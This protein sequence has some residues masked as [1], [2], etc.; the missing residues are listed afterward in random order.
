MPFFPSPDA[1]PAVSARILSR[2]TEVPMKTLLRC[3]SCGF[4]IEEGRLPDVCPACGVPRKLFEP[5]TETVSEKRL[6]VLQADLHPIAVH[7]PQ[8]YILTLLPLVGL[9]LLVP[10]WETTL[11]AAIRVLAWGLPFSIAL[12]MLA[13]LIDGKAR[14]RRLSTPILK[15]KISWG[16]GFLAGSLVTLAG[17]A[18]PAWPAPVPLALALG[19]MLVSAVCSSKLG[20]LGS[21]ILH[22][23]LPG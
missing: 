11:S 8:G 3:K 17:T 18:A 13:G 23:R 6:R 22:A 16:L 1:G 7:I 12:S 5:Y 10:A 15:Q 2:K 9:M 21:S 14:F 4:I 19:G 20:L